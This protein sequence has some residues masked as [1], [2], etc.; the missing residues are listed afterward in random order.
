M[1]NKDLDDLTFDFGDSPVAVA[2][3]PT[4]KPPFNDVPVATKPAEV[5][6]KKP[7]TKRRFPARDG[8]LYFD[9]ETVPDYERMELFGLDEIPA[10]VERRGV[11]EPER[12]VA[13]TLAKSLTVIE[14]GLRTLNPNDEF[15][16]MLEKAEK[17]TPKPRKGLI[18]L[19]KE[20]K[21]QDAARDAAVSAQRKTMSVTPEMCK[22]VAFGWAWG[23]GITNSMVVGDSV[24]EADLVNHFWTLAI[25]AKRVCGFNVLNFDLPVMFTRS[26]ILDISPTRSFDLKPWGN[27]VIDLMAKR[28]PKGPSTGLKKL[29]K[30]LGI[31]VPAGDVD[32]SQTEELWRKDSVK[33]GE[34][35]RS[36]VAITQALHLLYHE[37]FC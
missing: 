31:P 27:D 24:T 12:M 28:W 36:D 23:G 25:S 35:V 15:L 21:E 18:D 29:A 14:N 13:E 4:P 3:P 20:L 8:I 7:A 10:K 22:I 5:V 19:I 2:E 26:I 32:G 1:T 33:L 11:D 16:D 34:Y 37:F 9:L 30:M 6:D 17:A